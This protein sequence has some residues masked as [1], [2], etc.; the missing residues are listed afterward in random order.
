VRRLKR[1]SA[2][3]P[4]ANPTRHGESLPRLAAGG[5]PGAGRFHQRENDSQLTDGIA[6]RYGC[7]RCNEIHV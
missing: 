4:L 5:K 1:I 7:G 2:F 3:Y 6:G